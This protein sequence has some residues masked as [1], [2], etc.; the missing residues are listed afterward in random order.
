MESIL[1]PPSFSPDFL[2]GK[3][4]L[5]RCLRNRGTLSNA[6]C[7]LSDDPPRASIPLPPLFSTRF[8]SMGVRQTPVSNSVIYLAYVCQR[9]PRF[10]FLS[11]WKTLELMPPNFPP[12]FLFLLHR[13]ARNEINLASLFC[14][15]VFTW[16][17]RKL[18]RLSSRL[19]MER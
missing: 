12:P 15:A 7:S 14:N 11:L 17:C 5:L 1:S 6:L 8:V 4:R 2:L 9:N 13:E 16:I 10:L 18:S 19:D 3:T